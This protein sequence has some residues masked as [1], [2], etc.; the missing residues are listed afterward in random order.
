MRGMRVA[1][2]AIREYGP[3]F[4][5]RKSIDEPEEAADLTR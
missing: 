4:F 5:S 2:A 1:G 3:P